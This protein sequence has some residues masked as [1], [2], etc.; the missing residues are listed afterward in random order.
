MV[1]KQQHKAT[2]EVKNFIKGIE[3]SIFLYAVLALKTMQKPPIL[4]RRERQSLHL[5]K[6]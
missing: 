4:F 6:R 3:V 1:I 2:S 5:N